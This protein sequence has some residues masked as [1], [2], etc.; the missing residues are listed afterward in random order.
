MTVLP[1]FLVTGGA[2][3]IGG[4][5]VRL[6]V[7]RGAEVVV[8]DDLST[9]HRDLVDPRAELVVGSLLDPAARAR[10]FA[11]G[12]YDAV[13]HFA[14]RSLV[15]ES[16]AQPL[17]YWR[18][19][20][21]GTRL[22]AEAMLAHGVNRLVFSS[23]AAVYGVPARVPIPEDAPARPDQPLWRDEARDRGDAGRAAPCPWAALGVAALL[24]RRRRP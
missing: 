9:G 22:L 21:E 19:N 6:L 7:E 5:M 17:A 16:V 24:Q 10:A 14:A 3:Y 1:R 20:V 12:P 23:T 15:G 8:F 18:N 4:H 2:G 11:A 13:I